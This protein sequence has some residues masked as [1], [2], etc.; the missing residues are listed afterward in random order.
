VNPY[1]GFSPV[2]RVQALRWLKGEYAAGRRQRPTS[3][4][5]CGQTEGIIQAHSEDYSQPFG[6]HIGAFGFCYRCHVML[7]SR[8]RAPEAWARYKA[9]LVA[10]VTFQPFLVA[11]WYGF[12][13][14]HLLR[15]APAI[16]EPGP[17]RPDILSRIG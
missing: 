13:A 14:Q 8:H 7:H 2:Q 5:G 10:G 1:N 4:D 15:W 3:C 6:D 17:P 12:R 9:E 16:G 11:N